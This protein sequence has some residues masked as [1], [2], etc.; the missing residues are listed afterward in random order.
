MKKQNVIYLFILISAIV[1][2]YIISTINESNSEDLFS[3]RIRCSTDAKKEYE[4]MME[5]I[6]N[7]P[8][9]PLFNKK[10]EIY[11]DSSKNRCFLEYEYQYST[12]VVKSIK[13]VYTNELVLDYYENFNKTGDLSLS[14]Y[15]NEFKKLFNK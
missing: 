15:E 6:E 13:D 7:E 2:T 4:K 11:F 1:L 12:V 10:Y 3:N 8:G 5:T 9:A 14:E